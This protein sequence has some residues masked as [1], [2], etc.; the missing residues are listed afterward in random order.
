MGGAPGFSDGQADARIRK[1]V[2]ADMDSEPRSLLPALPSVD[3]GEFS[4]MRESFM[5][6]QGLEAHVTTAIQNEG[7]RVAVPP[8]L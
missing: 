1:F 8:R 6:S 7:Y 5:A 2:L 3:P 4:S